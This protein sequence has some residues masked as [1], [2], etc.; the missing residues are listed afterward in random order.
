MNSRTAKRILETLNELV[1]QFQA[2]E[3]H[4][5]NLANEQRDIKVKEHYIAKG[6]AY[7]ECAESLW[8]TTKRIERILNEVGEE[9]TNA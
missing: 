1:G 5:W 4:Y 7:C 3:D 6:E 8:V 2:T 9:G